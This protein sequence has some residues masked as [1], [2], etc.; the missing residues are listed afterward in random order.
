M[1]IFLAVLFAA[2]LHACWNAIIKFGDD[3]FQGM[4]LL[5]FGHI[6]FGLFLIALYPVPDPQSWLFLLGSVLCHLIYKFF[7]TFAYIKGDLSRVY[8]IARGTAPMIVLTISLLFLPDA[9]GTLQIGGI[10]LIG[11][12][13]LL[14]AR[15]VISHKEKQALIPFALMAAVG[16]AGYSLFDGLGARA[17][18]TALGYVGWLFF[19]DSSLFVIGG[20]ALRGRA[21]IPKS[22]LVWVQGLLASG[23]SVAAY[24]IAVWAMTVAPIAVITALREISVLFAVIIGIFFF[25][26]NASLEK[27]ISAL[28][29]VAGVIAIGF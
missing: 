2:L 12:G 24:S 15:G 19:L 10:L 14:M 25:K 26:E 11:L 7:L 22:K 16:T 21:I 4:L 20:F 5:S 28:M 9:V 17:A 29:I 1:S 13:I 18:G 8:P 6:F 27:L 23:A 3:K